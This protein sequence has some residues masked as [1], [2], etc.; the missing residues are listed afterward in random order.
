M[1]V[2]KINFI[3]SLSPYLSSSP[4]LL[5]VVSSHGS[6]SSPSSV[7]PSLSNQSS[8]STSA[9]TTLVFSKSNSL[10][11]QSME[12]KRSYMLGMQE[13][14]A[15]SM[16]PIVSKHSTRRRPLFP[17]KSGAL[18]AASRPAQR[19]GL[20]VGS[21]CGAHGGKLEHGG[22]LQLGKRAQAEARLA[23]AMAQGSRLGM[24][25]SDCSSVAG[26]QRD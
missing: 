18:L 6:L 10:S 7:I 25:L 8:E 22:W 13:V 15:Q 21:G 5:S 24:D 20:W 9:A 1:L 14:A 3:L 11:K 26:E 16:L 19:R 17:V 4:S 2:S 23:P 12:G